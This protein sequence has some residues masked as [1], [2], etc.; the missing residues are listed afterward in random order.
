MGQRTAVLPLGKGTTPQPG[1]TCIANIF[2]C[3]KSCTKTLV[4]DI[5]PLLRT[6]TV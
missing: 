4:A 6:V 5:D 1:G 2:G 3:R